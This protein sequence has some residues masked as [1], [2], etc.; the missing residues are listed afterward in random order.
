MHNSIYRLLKQ[1]KK[2]TAMQSGSFLPPEPLPNSIKAK[3]LEQQEMAE[4]QAQSQP[5]SVDPQ[6]AQMQKAQQDAVNQLQQAQQQL[7][8]TQTELQNVQMQ[9]QQQ[10]QA[11]QMQAQQDIQ[12]AQMDAQYELQAEKIKN[13][14]KLLSMQE[15]YMRS[16]GKAKPDQNHILSSQLKRVVRKVNSLKSASTAPAP[17]PRDSL[18]Q[19]RDADMQRAEKKFSGLPHSSVLPS[20]RTQQ[21]WNDISQWKKNYYNNPQVKQ[22]IEQQANTAQ[23]AADKNKPGFLS[24]YGS[25]FKDYL[26]NPYQEFEN[27]KDFALGEYDQRNPE[28]GFFSKGFWQDAGRNFAK[29]PLGT[30][31]RAGSN[32]F[33]GYAPNMVGGTVE[34]AKGVYNLDPA[35]AAKGLG[36]AALGVGEGLLTYGT[37]GAGGALTKALQAP[38]RAV[39]SGAKKILSE[40]GQKFFQ[41]GVGKGVATLGKGAVNLGVQVPAMTGIY[42]GANKLGLGN[43]ADYEPTEEDLQYAEDTYMNDNNYGPGNN[44]M[45]I[46]PGGL[47]FPGGF[48][49]PQPQQRW[50]AGLSPAQ[51]FSIL[52][53]QQDMYKGASNVLKNTEYPDIRKFMKNPPPAGEYIPS[54]IPI[55]QAGFKQHEFEK[56]F[57]FNTS[58]YMRQQG[59]GPLGDFI[60]QLIF[61]VGFPA[62]GMRNPME[63]D[64]ARSFSSL[65]NN[66]AYKLNN[67]NLF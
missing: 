7:S 64:F 13:Q 20:Q 14:Q 37:L 10:Q 62:L 53:T 59:Y 22:N 66:Q 33:L 54:P 31:L 51:R 49:A 30:T 56:P 18:T 42:A 39:A 1:V 47:N 15:K 61:Q 60:K 11:T 9:A 45:N 19:K 27:A 25:A 34:A 16:A 24:S 43:P 17:I 67:S 6:L 3:Q 38:G 21:Q 32:L 44:N 36:T 29:N 58:P 8:Q 65:R 50:D 5:D 55:L 52:N 48:T 23:A 26:D 46:G 40:G 63:P 35:R 12:K 28:A 41:S 4:Q 2:A 57:G